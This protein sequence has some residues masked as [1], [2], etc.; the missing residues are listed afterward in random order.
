MEFNN[1]KSSKEVLKELRTLK[2]AGG[3]SVETLSL[4]A[5]VG[6][7][8]V[9]KANT[10]IWE[11]GDSSEFVAVV[12][13][14]L[15]EVRRFSDRSED[16]IMGFFGTSDVIGLS[17]VL[18]GT[19]YPGSA[20]V[21]STEAVVLK[22]YLRP[23]LKM[24]DPRALE[25]HTWAREMYLQHEQTLRDK[26]DILNAGRVED[27]VYE[28]LSHLMRRFGM[29]NSKVHC[30]IPLSLTRQQVATMVNS[31]VETIIRL[32]NKWQKEGLI[33]WKKSEIIIENIVLLER[34]LHSTGKLK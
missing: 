3:L 7:K 19:P 10:F 18:N 20:K 12:V 34:S 15:V 11:M 23:I 28:F 4:L 14:G 30:Q 8:R 33:T 1:D 2:C 22:L 24:K 25:L 21:I 29:Y 16:M 13:N 26:I 31:R 27:R 9:F 32:I 6:S 17:A 5:S